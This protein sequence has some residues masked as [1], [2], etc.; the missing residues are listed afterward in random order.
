MKTFLT[1]VA[2]A[3]AVKLFDFSQATVAHSLIS[4]QRRSNFLDEV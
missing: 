3:L 2:V 1:I 4:L